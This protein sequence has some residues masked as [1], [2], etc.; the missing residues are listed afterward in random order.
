[1]TKD[2]SSARLA[3]TVSMSRVGS[4]QIA[5]GGVSPFASV[6]PLSPWVSPTSATMKP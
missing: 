5:H 4:S 2:T 1:M 6:S 3:V